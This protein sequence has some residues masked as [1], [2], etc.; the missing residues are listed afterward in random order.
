MQNT[1]QITHVR[2]RGS[3]GLAILRGFDRIGIGCDQTTVRH[4]PRLLSDIGASYISGALADW[5]ED[6][7]MAHLRGAPYHPK[8]KGKIERWQQTFKNRLLP[9]NT[10]LPGDLRQRIE[11]FVEHDNHR[12][13]DES[14][15]HLTRAG[16]DFGRVETFMKQRERITRKTIETRHLQH[17][18]SAI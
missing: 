14:L 16:V 2:F 17:R 12:R 4:K 1:D 7:N 9:E 15:H 13:Y 3:S 8:T 10:Y 5:L 11:A 6:Q 18:K